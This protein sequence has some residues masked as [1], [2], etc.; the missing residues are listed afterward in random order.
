MRE[1]EW[2]AAHTVWLWLDLSPSMEFR[3]S[4][5]PTSKCERAL[6]LALATAELLVQSGER[7]GILGLVPPAV[8]KGVAQKLAEAWLRSMTGA[9]PPE[10]L[11]PRFVFGR[12]SA[13]VL[14]SDFLEPIETIRQ[15]LEE[16]AAQGVRGHLVQVLDPAEETLPYQGRVEFIASEGPLRVLTDR[17][18][19]VR[20]QYR[21]LLEAHRE[22]LRALARRFEWQY[23]LHHSDRPA[24]EAMLA[25]YAGLAGLNQPGQQADYRFKSG[26]APAAPADSVELAPPRAAAGGDAP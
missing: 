11:P 12:H 18:E 14:I 7:A 1:R 3:S 24:T 8:Q 6:V 4:L 19:S 20:D 21:R 22:A 10:S 13:C 25:L 26:G 17:A 5:S 2:E 23:T 15:S 16:Y 9:A